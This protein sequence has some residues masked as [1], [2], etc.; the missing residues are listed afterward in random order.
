MNEEKKSV[1]VQ[2]ESKV[3]GDLKTEATEMAI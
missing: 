1:A 2:E 3:D